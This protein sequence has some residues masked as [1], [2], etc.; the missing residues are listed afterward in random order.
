VREHGG[1][2]A[3]H[4]YACMY[5][6]VDVDFRNGTEMIYLLNLNVVPVYVMIV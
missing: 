4:V 5:T 1:F 3:T 2:E 6:A